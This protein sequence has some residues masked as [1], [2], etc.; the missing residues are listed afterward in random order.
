MRRLVLPIAL[1]LA[2]TILSVPLRAEAVSWVSE[3]RY[4]LVKFDAFQSW[5]YARDWA[6]NNFGTT[7]AS[8]TSMEEQQDVLDLWTSSGYP[9][10]AAVFLGGGFSD[11]DCIDGYWLDGSEFDYTNWALGEP[12]L[13]FTQKVF[14]LDFAGDW[15]NIEGDL[16]VGYLALVN[17][18]AAVSAPLTSP[19]SVI[20]PSRP[21]PFR[22]STS[23]RFHLASAER[24]SLTIHDVRGRVVR[25]LLQGPQPSGGRE[26]SWDGRDG[27]GIGVPA[28]VYF[29]RLRAGTLEATGKMVRS[30]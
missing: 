24:V 6:L 4:T 30:K 12:N 8:V 15:Y 5:N 11:S 20:G 7:L 9:T 17:N 3:G 13:C 14:T 19:G 10:F 2:L 26:V 18:P 22:A 25:T 21:N 27:N 28:G 23:I 1:A 16:S 29:Y